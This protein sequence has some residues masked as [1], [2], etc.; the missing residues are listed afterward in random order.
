MPQ[1]DEVRALLAVWDAPDPGV[2]RGAADQL[3][4]ALDEVS[5]ALHP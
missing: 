1:W 5:E 3:L 2:L 4:H